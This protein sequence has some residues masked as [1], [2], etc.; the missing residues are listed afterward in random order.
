MTST[1]SSSLTH[2]CT[3]HTVIHK[4]FEVLLDIRSFATS[5]KMFLHDS[6]IILYSDQQCLRTPVFPTLSSTACCLMFGIFLAR[7]EV[8]FQSVFHLNCFYPCI[9]SE[10]EY[11]FIHKTNFYFLLLGLSSFCLCIFF[12][13]DFSFGV[14]E[15]LP[16]PN[17]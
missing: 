2:R 11:L 14:L 3:T 17:I 8:V 16:S 13:I 5:C 4:G 1:P 15:V 9:L 7:Y 10:T 6:C 12:N